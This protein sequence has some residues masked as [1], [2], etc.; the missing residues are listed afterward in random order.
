MVSVQSNAVVSRGVARHSQ[1]KFCSAHCL[2]RLFNGRLRLH[3]R[4]ICALFDGISLLL[5]RHPLA[6]IVL[7]LRLTADSLKA[8]RLE[9]NSDAFYLR[10]K[11]RLFPRI[12]EVFRT[13]MPEPLPTKS[14]SPLHEKCFRCA[15]IRIILANEEKSSAAARKAGC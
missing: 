12:V 15:M 11:L 7:K 3:M 8:T 5:R 14:E 9:P 4:S 10:N 13:K 2:P 1:K 6:C